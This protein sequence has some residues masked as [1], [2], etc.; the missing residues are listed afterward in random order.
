MMANGSSMSHDNMAN[1]QTA[2]PPLLNEKQKA[3]QFDEDDA[4]PD[5]LPFTL[6]APLLSQT[7]IY[8]VLFSALV[9]LFY[10]R[11]PPDKLALNSIY[12]I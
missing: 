4:D 6:L 3:P 7:T 10:Q 9:L 1:C 12:R 11:I 5:P 8:A 2:C